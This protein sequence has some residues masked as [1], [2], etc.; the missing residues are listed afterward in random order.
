[1]IAP[2]GPG[3]KPLGLGVR[4]AAK[5]LDEEERGTSIGTP[6]VIRKMLIVS[7]PLLV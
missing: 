5:A 7:E 1:M 4:R 2:I 6:Q 3:G